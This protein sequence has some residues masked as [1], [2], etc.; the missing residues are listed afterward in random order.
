M[1]FSTAG[2]L[3]PYL[4]SEDAQRDRFWRMAGIVQCPS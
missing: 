4:N 2:R 3:W 1:G